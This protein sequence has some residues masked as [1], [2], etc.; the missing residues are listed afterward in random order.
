M[1]QLVAHMLMFIGKT[2]QFVAEVVIRKNFNTGGAEA[3]F[4]RSSPPLGRR[5]GEPAQCI[6]PVAKGFRTG[7]WFCHLP[8]FLQDSVVL[9]PPRLR[10][11]HT[12][13]PSGGITVA[14]IA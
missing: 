8:G 6:R 5:N 2:P 4:P 9:A 11:R 10:L 3:L 1:F 12:D 13:I 7:E 14:T